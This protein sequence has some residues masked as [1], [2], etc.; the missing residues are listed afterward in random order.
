MRVLIA[1]AAVVLGS[2]FPPSARAETNV[3]EP[4]EMTGT[5]KSSGNVLV[6][7]QGDDRAERSFVVMTT[8]AMPAEGIAAGERV[9]IRYRPI[10]AERFAALSIAR[11]ATGSPRAATG[12]AGPGSAVED[13]DALVAY[14][15]LG[16]LV[17][18]IVAAAVTAFVGVQL[19]RSARHHPRAH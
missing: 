16:A 12:G 1:V 13:Q 11:P 9:V 6:L 4:L 5:V 15:T 8:T 14:P 3:R 17:F 7:V 10:D 18:L 19:L 2:A